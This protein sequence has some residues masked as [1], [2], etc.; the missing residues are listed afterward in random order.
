MAATKWQFY[1][2]AKQRLL[3]GGIDLDNNQ[4]RMALFR[5]S[6]SL[7]AEMFTASILAQVGATVT[8]SGYKGAISIPVVIKLTDVSSAKMS[9]GSVVFSA[10]TIG[11]INSIQY[12]IIYESS[13]GNLLCFCKL[14]TSPFNVTTGNTLTISN[15]GGVFVLSGGSTA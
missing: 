12:A 7:T 4:M 6:A 13:T 10:S 3:T 11:D 5:N 1:I 14:S 2:T 15:T 9:I 8:S